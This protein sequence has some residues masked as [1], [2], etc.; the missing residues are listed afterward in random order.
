[1]RTKRALLSKSTNIESNGFWLAFSISGLLLTLLLSHITDID[2][3]IQA[4]LFDTASGNWLLD[5][6]EPTLKLL[7]YDGIKGILVLLAVLLL[8]LLVVDRFWPILG[9]L[10]RASTI[11]LLSLILV[12]GTVGVIKATSNTPCPRDLSSFGG[13]L[14]YVDVLDS[15]PAGS[16]PAELQQCYPAGHA[17]GGFALLAFTL[18]ASSLQGRAALAVMALFIGWSMG[19]YKMAIGDHFL[20]HTLV[21]MLIGIFIISCLHRY[22]PKTERSL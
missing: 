13:H 22:F 14:P 16:Q 5:R 21:T 11:A 12:P 18:L 10:R 20:S 3:V 1:M 6:D 9:T 7:F 2:L 17:S 15:W 4:S 19:I 8:A